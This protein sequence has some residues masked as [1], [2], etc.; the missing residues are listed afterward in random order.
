M[1]IGILILRPPPFGLMAKHQTT[2]HE[3]FSLFDLSVLYSC[4]IV[5]IELVN[6]RDKRPIEIDKIV[7]NS[8]LAT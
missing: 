1:T 8:I 5:Q 7:M 2:V 6:G 4:T 3:Y